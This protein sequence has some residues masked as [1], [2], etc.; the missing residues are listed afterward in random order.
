MYSH[1][2]A[3]E[4]RNADLRIASSEGEERERKQRRKRKT[5]QGMWR[6]K[7]GVGN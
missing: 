3:R 6:K 1:T 4:I 5:N 2:Q 7:S